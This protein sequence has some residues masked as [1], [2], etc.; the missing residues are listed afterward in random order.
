MKISYKESEDKLSC[1][2]YLED[3]FIGSVHLNVYKQKWFLKP[4]FKIPGQF[5]AANSIYDSWYS[6]GKK[7]AQLYKSWGQTYTAKKP[8]DEID[9]GVDLDEILSFLKTRR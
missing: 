5:F 4:G 2:V 6:A 7:L 9:F 1:D 3:T 8:L